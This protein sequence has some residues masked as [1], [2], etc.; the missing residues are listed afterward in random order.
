MISLGFNST[1]IYLSLNLFVTLRI[2]TSIFILLKCTVIGM[3]TL[4]TIEISHMQCALIPHGKQILR[5]LFLKYMGLWHPDPESVLAG[6]TFGVR[7]FTYIYK[8]VEGCDR[9]DQ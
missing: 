7:I 2:S 8:G 6:G 3:F 5:L 9:R 4:Y 1:N